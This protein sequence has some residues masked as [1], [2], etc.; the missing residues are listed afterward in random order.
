MY[1]D[2]CSWTLSEWGYVR[3]HV[4]QLRHPKVGHLCSASCSDQQDIVAGEVTVDDRI[5]VEVG[6]SECYIMADV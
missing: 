4:Y 2:C 5:V 6:H 3:V 1:I